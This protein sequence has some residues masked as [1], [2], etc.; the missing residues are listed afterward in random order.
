MRVSQHNITGEKTMIIFNTKYG[1]LIL[2]A[3]NMLLVSLTACYPYRA[4]WCEIENTDRAK[5]SAVIA[6]LRQA[7][8]FK[9]Y[10]Q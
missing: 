9:K 10:G 3:S 8:L 7:E 1:K 4:I 5:K 2:L 6:F